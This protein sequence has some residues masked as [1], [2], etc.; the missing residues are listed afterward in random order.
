MDCTVI[1]VQKV[2]GR[3]WTILILQSLYHK[4]NL[5]FNQI[6]DELA[7]TTNKVLSNRLK[8]LESDDIIKRLVVI[9]KPLKVE[10]SLTKKGND[11][12]HLFNA[13]KEWGMKYN[14]VPEN[15]LES[16]CNSCSNKECKT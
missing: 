16:N 11:L 6:S 14:L 15:C 3:K 8:E 9:S 10:Y 4:N 12:I 1:E 5:S 2:L 13:T 7:K